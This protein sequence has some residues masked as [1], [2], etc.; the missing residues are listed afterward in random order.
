[1]KSIEIPA[2]VSIIGDKAFNSCI[3]LESVYDYAV[4]PQELGTEVFEFDG[5][6]I[7]NTDATYP[8]YVPALSVDAY[9]TAWPEYADRI[10]PMNLDAS[11]DKFND[12]KEW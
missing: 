5:Y 11:F 9:K 3:F 12:E 2:S 1:M 8:I 10:K 4:A 6:N 7:S